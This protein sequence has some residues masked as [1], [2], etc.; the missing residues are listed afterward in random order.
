MR[1]LSTAVLLLGLSLQ[2]HA[3]SE[4]R[5]VDAL[6]TFQQ[7]REGDAGRI[8]PAI[9]AFEALALAEPRQPVYGAYLGSAMGLRAR[10]AL[11]P[12]N[13]LKFSEQGLDH[14]DRALAALKPEHD[15]LLL[16]GVPASLE[17]RLVAANMFISLPEPIFHRRASGNKL[18]EEV[19]KHPAYDAAPEGFRKAVQRAADAAKAAAK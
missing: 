7:A 16:R 5:F 2:S 19:R 14:I 11:M 17:T 8:E 18:I 9:A 15:K 6:K 12:W 13:K 1:I 3:Q 10:D 4:A